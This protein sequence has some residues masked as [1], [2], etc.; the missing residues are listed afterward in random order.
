MESYIG[1]KI[2]LAEPQE[3]EGKEGYRVVY[4]DNYVSWSPKSVFE[5]AYR[6]ISLEEKDMIYK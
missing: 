1:A 2:I 3:K 4:P 5:Q 6:K